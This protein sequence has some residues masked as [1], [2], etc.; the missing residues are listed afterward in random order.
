MVDRSGTQIKGQ[1]QGRK[2]CGYITASR[3]SPL[4]KGTTHT[5]ELESWIEVD[6]VTIQSLSL[7]EAELRII[8]AH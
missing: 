2:F 1:Y 6:R 8:Q 4:W 7:S 5:V 3:R